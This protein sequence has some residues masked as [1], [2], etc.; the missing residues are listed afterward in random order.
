MSKAAQFPTS[1][2]DGSSVTRLASGSESGES[3]L[4]IYQ[5][6]DGA[7]Y[8]QIQAEVISLQNMLKKLHGATNTAAVAL[9][10]TSGHL[11]IPATAGVPTGVPADVPA[12]FVAIAYDTTNHKISVYDGGWKQSVAL[13]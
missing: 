13:S 6:P 1:I 5:A 9:A 2:W 7:D 8:Q 11:K 12:G 10:A 4:D 3:P